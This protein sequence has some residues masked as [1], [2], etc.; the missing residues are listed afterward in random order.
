MRVHG[1]VSF[2]KELFPKHA[3]SRVGL[4]SFR[5]CQHC[6]FPNDTQKTAWSKKG[7]GLVK[8]ANPSTDA[9]GLITPAEFTAK[10]GCAHCGSL[11]W[12]PARP[13]KLKNEDVS[14]TRWK[15]RRRWR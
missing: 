12:T 11:N 4:T 15:S 3:T 5:R 2:G 1:R 14:L 6:G 13:K 10:T 7:E 9:D 8:T